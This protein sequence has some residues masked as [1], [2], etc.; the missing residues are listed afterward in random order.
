MVHAGSSEHSQ[1]AS[2]PGPQGHGH[3][4]VPETTLSHQEH[5][6]MLSHDVT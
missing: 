1:A 2:P 3:A 6:R 4:A 5:A